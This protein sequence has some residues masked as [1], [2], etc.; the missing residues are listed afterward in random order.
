MAVPV[1]GELVTRLI[2]A[3]IDAYEAALR[4]QNLATLDEKGKAK[5]AKEASKASQDIYRPQ[6]ADLGQ[7]I[8]E[9]RQG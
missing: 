6:S 3:G 1:T 5:A 7:A 4:R 9:S 8:E 2:F